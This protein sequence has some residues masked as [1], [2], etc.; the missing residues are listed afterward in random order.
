MVTSLRGITQ[1]THC[2]AVQRT[3]AG[4]AGR[5]N[6]LLAVRTEIPGNPGAADFDL[7]TEIL[8]PAPDLGLLQRNLVPPEL[9]LIDG[10]PI[11][12][13]LGP[14]ILGNPGSGLLGPLTNFNT[15]SEPDDKPQDRT[16]TRPIPQRTAS[17]HRGTSTGVVH[18]PDQ[19]VAL[20][21]GAPK[22]R[23]GWLLAEAGARI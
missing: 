7:G 12:V 19:L 21:L 9:G 11:A 4:R 5:G 15:A 3:G 16:A 14:E 2:Q 6:G 22:M 13:G 8:T 20:V 17:S 18:G 10:D 23:S 1:G